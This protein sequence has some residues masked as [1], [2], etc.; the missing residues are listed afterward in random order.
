MTQ[1]QE[2]RPP[3]LFFDL[4]HRDGGAVRLTVAGEVDLSNAERLRDA[5]EQAFALSGTVELEMDDVPFID[6]QG[7]RAM[8]MPL[9]DGDRR[10]IVAGASVAVQRLLSVTGLAHHFAPPEE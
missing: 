6:S 8:T 1:R 3:A 2:S 5:I 7:I 4:T 9:R 10:L